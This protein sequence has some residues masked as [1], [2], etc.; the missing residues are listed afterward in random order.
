MIIKKFLKD[1]RIFMVSTIAALTFG[2]NWS[3]SDKDSV[4]T[5]FPSFLKKIRYLGAKIR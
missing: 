1:H 2:G 4:K 5:S 3:I